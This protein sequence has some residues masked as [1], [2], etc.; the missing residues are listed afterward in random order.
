MNVGE[1][2][3]EGFGRVNQ[4]VRQATEGVG[5]DGLLYRPE[6][7]ANSIAWLVWHL[8]RIQDDHISHLQGVVEQWPKW[9]E[10]T[11]IAVEGLGQG[12]G[13]DDVAAVRP[14]S[15][16]AL[17]RYHDAVHCSSLDYVMSISEA[18]L[19]SVID[20]SYTPPVTRGVRLVSVLS[21][22]LQHAG[23]ARYLRGIVDRLGI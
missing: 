16:D 23:Q 13:P 14:L 17:V 3:A 11:G 10:E 22:N 21:D 4:L 15:V 20:R 7:G 2:L 19:D 8:T 12:D 5:M 1:L 9:M 6:P 18:D